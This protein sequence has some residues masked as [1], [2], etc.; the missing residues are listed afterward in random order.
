MKGQRW[1]F[2]STTVVCFTLPMT[3]V[4]WISTNEQ[5]SFGAQR[6]PHLARFVQAGCPSVLRDMT[7]YAARNDPRASTLFR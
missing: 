4:V 2:F 5:G 7:F 1:L 6:Q 3:G